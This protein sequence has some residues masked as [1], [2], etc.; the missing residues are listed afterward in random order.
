MTQFSFKSCDFDASNDRVVIGDVA[1]FQF[2]R[3]D[4]FSVSAWVK[5]VTTSGA[6]TIVS[7]LDASAP[8]SGWE[9]FIDAANDELGVQL[10]NTVTTNHLRVDTSGA[11]LPNNGAWQHVCF[12][13]D[14]S[15]TPG[16]I[17]FYINGVVRSTSTV[18]NN[19]SATIAT[20]TPL[21]IGARDGATNPFND[22]I[23]D[24][25]I[26]DI[27][28]T[29]GEVAAI[30]AGGT[31][32]DNRL[33]STSIDL[34]GYWTMGDG[35]TFPN[36]KDRQVGNAILASGSVQD[37]SDSSNDGTPTNMEDS[38]F[39]ADT[40]G[41]TSGYSAI[42]DG[43]DEY[44]DIGNPAEL[45]FAHD[46]E[47]TIS[48]WF[49][50]SFSGSQQTIVS[51][52]IQGTTNRGYTLGTLDDQM[53]LELHNT[54][55]PGTLLIKVDT[56]L[57]NVND[58]AWHHI[59]ASYD[60]TVT[61]VAANVSFVLDGSEPSLSIE[62]DNLTGTISNSSPFV[63][64]AVADGYVSFDGY[65]DDV[66]VYDRVLTVAERQAIYNSGAPTDNTLLSTES[67]L[68]GYWLM[69]EDANDG[70]MTSML[71]GD[72]V[73]DAPIGFVGGYTWDILDNFGTGNDFGGELIP[74]TSWGLGGSPGIGFP[75]VTFFMRGIDSAGPYPSYHTWE[76]LDNPDTDGSEAGTLPF[77][78]PLIEITVA[79]VQE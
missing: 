66:A 24:V 9:F 62:D 8:N 26:Y 75:G 43:I 51:K 10:I 46:D 16:G 41:G 67:N 17:L 5:T 76:V 29:S 53:Y 72:I 38:G 42:L 68:V 78:G 45:D 47:F 70:V 36:L 59:A 11:I 27:E 40:P 58:G 63:I 39:I 77:G 19:L 4:S 3:T 1:P 69:G 61:Q 37:R 12:T 65:I 54:S 52:K 25:A 79:G 73:T 28:L 7:K 48:A 14:G 64:G 33:L 60:G 35:D 74:G 71:S 15:S 56:D 22:R 13:Y 57:A 21:Q 6:D 20:A 18:T 32:V 49:K 34:V 31:P 50:T 23:D 44:I 55:S 30:Y 2:E